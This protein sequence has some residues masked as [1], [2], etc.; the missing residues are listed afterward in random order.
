MKHAYNT[1]KSLTSP[2]SWGSSFTLPATDYMERDIECSEHEVNNYLLHAEI[3]TTSIYSYSRPA[4]HKAYPVTSPAARN[5]TGTII[6]YRYTVQVLGTRYGS[7]GLVPYLKP[8]AL[9]RIFILILIATSVYTLK[10]AAGHHNRWGTLHM[11]PHLDVTPLVVTC[12]C[13]QARL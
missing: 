8:R 3:K 11:W 7:F 13:S 4:S 10:S 5:Q 1:H 2:F 6:R 9:T 12:M